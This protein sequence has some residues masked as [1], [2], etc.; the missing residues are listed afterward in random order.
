[1]THDQSPPTTALTSLERAMAKCQD[2]AAEA[3][4]ASKGPPQ[5]DADGFDHVGGAGGQFGRAMELMKMTAK[6]GSVMAKLSSHRSQTHYVHRTEIRATQPPPGSAPA[7]LLTQV[8]DPEPPMRYY[9]EHGNRREIT[10]EE[11]AEYNA[12]ADR[13][14]ERVR[15]ARLAQKAGQGAPSPNSSGSNRENGPRIRY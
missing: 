11:T 14:A 6:L 5:L 9:D 8:E 1:M 4:A 13:Q 10:P 15:R 7:L 12:W 2:E 3:L